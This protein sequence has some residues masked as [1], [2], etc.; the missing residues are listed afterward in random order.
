[1]NVDNRTA[2]TARVGEQTLEFVDSFNYFGS[3]TCY[4]GDASDNI[5]NRLGKARS[6]F[7]RLQQVTEVS[8]ET[9]L[10]IYRSCVLCTLLYR[11]E[12]W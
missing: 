8:T 3:T 7:M 2:E 11:S 1:M 5:P 6:T 4:N 12:C 9:K 10:K